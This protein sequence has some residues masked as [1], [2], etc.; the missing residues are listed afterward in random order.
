MVRTRVAMHIPQVMGG[1]RAHVQMFPHVS[2]AFYTTRGGV[3]LRVRTCASLFCILG[4][5]GR[6][7]LKFGKR[8]VSATAHLF[9]LIYSPPFVHR[10][11][12]VLLVT[13]GR[14]SARLSL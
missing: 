7:A 4:M 13:S 10:L 9:M 5:V 2:Y 8:P 11:K 14:G 6:T 3:H 12:S 1:V